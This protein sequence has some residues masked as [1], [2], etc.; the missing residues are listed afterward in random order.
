MIPARKPEF[1]PVPAGR[2]IRRSVPLAALV[3]AA[4]LGACAVPLVTESELAT[5]SG[6]Y[7]EERRQVEPISTDGNLRRYVNCV[8]DAIVAELPEPYRSKEWDVEIF[9][10]PEEVQAFAMTG[11][12]IG[13]YTGIFKAAREQDQLG[14]VIGHEVAHVTEQHALKRV[15]RELTTRGAVMAG[16]AVLGG[17]Y[18]MGQILSMGAQLGL[19]LPYSRGNETEADT[20]GLKYMAQAGFN[21]RAAIQLW[22]NMEEVSK[23][24]PPQFLSTHPSGDTRIQ[25]LIRQLPEALALYNQAQAEGRRPDC[26]P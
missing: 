12:R 20:V 19:S 9:D 17:G 10:E 7:F 2:P 26:G 3:L 4:L 25:D 5:E 11:G 18:A 15:N 22:K 8:V 13:V 14:A 1:F 21:P 16:T 6:R 24:A 23:L